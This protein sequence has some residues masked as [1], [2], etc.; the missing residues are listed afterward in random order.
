M[1]DWKVGT[2]VYSV[3][4]TTAGI[5]VRPPNADVQLSCGGEP[6]VTAPPPKLSGTPSEEFAGTALVGKRYADQDTGLELLCTKTG[7]GLFS[8]DGRQLEM[9]APAPLPSS[10]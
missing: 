8:V 10:D 9:K 5:V 3:V 4:G 6:V 7:N 2:Q 1:T